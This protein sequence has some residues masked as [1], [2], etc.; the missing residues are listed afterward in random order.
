MF[1]SK[2]RA[3]LPPESFKTV[4]A[5]MA[6]FRDF[7]GAQTPV[8]DL[9]GKLWG[10]WLRHLKLCVSEAKLARNTAR[11]T[12]TRSRQFFRWLV[13]KGLVAAIDGLARSGESILG[14]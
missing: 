8:A 12:Y 6:R 9:T 1:V 3:T 4:P 14:K 5:Q 7:V 11:V 2:L 13:D 10:L